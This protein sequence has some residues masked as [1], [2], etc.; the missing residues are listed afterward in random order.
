[1][2]KAPQLYQF[3]Q[4]HAQEYIF[5]F[6]PYM[7]ATTY[8]GAQICPERSIFIPCLHDEGYARMQI[9][10]QLMPQVRGMTFFVEA[11]RELAEQLY[12][13]PEHQLRQ[14][15]GAGVDTDFTADGARFR[16][17]YGLEGPFVLYTGRRES[18]KNVP[19]LIN[20]WQRYQQ[21]NGRQAQLV[22]IGPGQVNGPPQANIRDLG[23]VPVQDKYDAYAAAD[24]FCM[25]S[26]NE[27]FSIV[28]MES[29][30]AETAVLVHGHCAVT[31]EHCLK[32][33]GGLYFTNYEEFA[34]TVD[35]LLDH[36]QTARKMGKNGR[37]YV[38]ANFQWPQVVERYKQL[39]ATLEAEVVP[40]V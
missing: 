27:S 17:K 20:Y 14:V 7:F 37:A 22:L 16:Q 38:L 13:L 29:W 3:M 25:P 31:H 32:S 39:I 12:A 11:E 30:L 2:I 23:F 19:L 8:H 24:I 9:F 35:Y 40:H 6:I 5:F 1:M 33:N 10:R 15:V 18:G 4:Q 34:A 26:V 28:T 36:P 21:E